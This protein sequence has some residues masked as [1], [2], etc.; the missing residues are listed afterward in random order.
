MEWEGRGN[1]F[2]ISQTKDT[3]HVLHQSRENTL[4]CALL[5]LVS[6]RLVLFSAFL[7]DEQCSLHRTYRG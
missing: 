7:K 1:V 2:N 4:L 6:D 5:D 3:L